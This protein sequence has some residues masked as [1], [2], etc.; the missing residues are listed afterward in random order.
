MPV[1]GS[2]R[3]L[4]VGDERAELDML[5]RALETGGHPVQVLH[6][7]GTAAAPP[8][9][10]HAPLVMMLLPAA[11]PEALALLRASGHGDPAWP[12]LLVNTLADALALRDRGTGRHTERVIELVRDLALALGYAAG[13]PELIEMQRGALM[14]DIGKIGISDAILH[15]P[16]PLTDEE[17]VEM[18]LH[19]GYG[20]RMLKD[21][22][23]LAGVAEMIHASHERWDGAGYP[24]GLAGEAIPLG[25]R[26]LLVADAWDAMVSDRPY[27][28][29]MS[30]D[31]ARREIRV[32]AGTQFDPRVVAAFERVVA[33]WSGEERRASAA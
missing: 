16:G 10:E 12:D 11:E 4:L 20:Y 25:A 3:V 26:I 17:W 24:R 13:A 31:D 32:H 29:A 27:R 6:G 23:S 5:A 7:N 9:A 33:R 1:H 15:K 2:T 19:P 8:R 18:R 30:F 14:H 21:V 22:V 28:R